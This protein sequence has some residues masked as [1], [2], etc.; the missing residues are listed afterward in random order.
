MKRLFVKV[1][2]LVQR[3]FLCNGLRISQDQKSTYYSSGNC[4]G[5]CCKRTLCKYFICRF[6]IDQ[7]VKY[8]SHNDPSDH[9]CNHICDYKNRYFSFT[10]LTFLNIQLLRKNTD[11]H[12]YKRRS[13]NPAPPRASAP[14]QIYQCVTDESD[15]STCTF[16]MPLL[17]FIVSSSLSFSHC[18]HHKP[19]CGLA[20][21]THENF[22]FI[23]ETRIVY[24]FSE[25]VVNGQT[26]CL[27]DLPHKFPHRQETVQ[28]G[29]PD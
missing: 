4:V 21:Q 11:Y 22:C 14:G 27:Y 16:L 1:L 18:L 12:T 17:L 24:D 5:N 19:Q 7:N 26:L 6:C 2:L 10:E 23:Y 15:Q 13:D 25:E 8:R 28:S 29:F 9:M 20:V 3:T